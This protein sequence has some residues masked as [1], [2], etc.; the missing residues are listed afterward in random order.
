MD[1]M[2]LK[3]L[4]EETQKSFPPH[5]PTKTHGVTKEIPI[6]IENLKQIVDYIGLSDANI[7]IKNIVGKMIN[8]FLISSRHGLNKNNCD[9][10]IINQEIENGKK[11]TI[12]YS[13]KS[14]ELEYQN[15][16]VI[17]ITN[18]SDCPFV[19]YGEDYSNAI[20]SYDTSKP[21]NLLLN[22][23]FQNR[24]A[25]QSIMTFNS[26]GIEINKDFKI[27]PRTRS[28]QA[29]NQCITG[30]ITRSD[31]FYTANI[32][33]NAIGNDFGN[34][35]SNEDIENV[36]SIPEINVPIRYMGALKNDLNLLCVVSATDRESL[37]AGAIEELVGNYIYSEEDNYTFAEHYEESKKIIEYSNF[38]EFTYNSFSIGSP[39]IHAPY[40]FEILNNI[41]EYVHKKENNKHLK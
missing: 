21:N 29:T 35:I 11:I 38:L 5:Y 24:S 23:I 32:K 39:M 33:L 14:L 6:L 27:I 26:E 34:I 1:L 10:E 13:D 4:L 37:R 28:F 19:A 22:Q 30:S 3:S 36:N 17:T 25:C 41:K 31:D 20:I 16:G 7:A 8:E 18:N 15:N 2:N 40:S 12:S 9:F